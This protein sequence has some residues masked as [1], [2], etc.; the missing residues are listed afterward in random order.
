MKKV[1]TGYASIDDP[2]LWGIPFF[3]R[4]SFVP[5]CGFYRLLTL[6][7]FLSRKKYAIDCHDVHRTYREL[8]ADTARVRDFLC[9]RGVHRGDIVAASLP[10]NY[11]AVV[12][13]L[14]SN[15]V[16]AAVTFLNIAMSEDEKISYLNDFH[17]PVFFGFNLTAGSQKR[18]LEQTEIRHLILLTENDTGRG[19]APKGHTSQVPAVVSFYEMTAYPGKKPQYRIRGND[20]GMIGFTSGTSGKPKA[21]VLTNR[22]II[23]SI[24]YTRN[25]V[26][27]SQFKGT[28]TLT[29][30]P[31][32][33]PYGSVVSLLSSLLWGKETIL[34]PDLRISTIAYYYRKKP[35]LVFGSP[36]LLEMTLKGIGKDDDLSSV[37]HF[38]TGGDFLTE[39]S[40]LRSIEFFKEHGADVAIENG[41]GNAETAS[42][43]ATHFTLP[44]RPGSAGHMITGLKVMIADPETLEEKRYG[45]EGLLLVS[46]DTVF[47][48]YYNQPEQT[49]SAKITLKGRT[50]FKSGALGYLNEEG[51]FYVTARHARFF[52]D[53]QMNKV[54]GDYVQTKIATLPFVMD[55]AVIGVSHDTRLYVPKV[56]IVPDP[57]MPKEQVLELAEECFRQNADI[58][59]NNRSLELKQYEIPYEIELIDALPRK[60]GTDKIDYSVLE[61]RS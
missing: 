60:A 18:F 40:R 44:I 20:V 3:K 6:T 11:E 15:A 28:K 50:W 8:L 55:C 59:D 35:S 27:S 14:A 43:G 7:S 19:F 51:Y 33:Y 38:L 56:F 24:L 25:T 10:S 31:F 29:A 45:E 58:T 48:E 26:H 37:S 61:N 17:S 49:A 12:I 39:A 54:Y 9:A 57:S 16:G 2:H 4:H 1:L 42:S 41:Y 36:A 30:V 52:I 47:R 23:S 53:S 32:S 34:S 5:D 46:G 22:N 13:M 21:V